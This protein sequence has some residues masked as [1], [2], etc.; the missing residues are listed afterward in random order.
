MPRADHHA[1][2]RV[3]RI[4][5]GPIINDLRLVRRGKLPAFRAGGDRRFS[6]RAIERWVEDQSRLAHPF[7][8]GDDF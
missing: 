4:S 3:R 6:Q 1:G 5:A 8:D 7:G 2:E